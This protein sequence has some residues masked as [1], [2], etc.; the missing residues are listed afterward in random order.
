MNRC[1]GRTNCCTEDVI[2]AGGW[3]GE[4]N[5]EKALKIND[6][7]DVSCALMFVFVASV[8]KARESAHIRDSTKLQARQAIKLIMS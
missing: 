4:E 1:Q 8:P 7:L 5:Y 3:E 2:T 6:V